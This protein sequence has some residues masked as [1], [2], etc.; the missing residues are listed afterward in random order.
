MD[1]VNQFQRMIL[2]FDTR[3]PVMKDL[4]IIKSVCDVT[5]ING[6]DKMQPDRDHMLRVRVW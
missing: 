3:V 6:S 1:P 5:K 2:A 4:E